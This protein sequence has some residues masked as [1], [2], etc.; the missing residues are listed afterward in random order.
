[1]AKQDNEI[2]GL[3]NLRKGSLFYIIA[4]ILEIIGLVLIVPSALTLTLSGI[5]SEIFTIIDEEII[6]VIVSE[7]LIILWFLSTRKGFKTLSNLGKD[8]RGGVTATTLILIGILIEIVGLLV[9]LGSI[10]A[11]LA[12]INTS[13][14][15]GGILG[16]V[17]ASIGAIVI[18]IIGAIIFF[19][20]SIMVGLAYRA[21]GDIYNNNNLRTGGLLIV[22]GNIL[23]IIPYLDI[24][25]AILVFIGYILVY[26]G[27]GSVITM[28]SKTSPQPYM[29]QSTLST[30]IPPQPSAPLSQIGTGKL[31][32]NGIAE[33]TIYSQVA[34]QI[35]SAA[36]LG[37]NN[38]TSDIFPAQLN[39]GYNNVKINFKV[40]LSLVAGNLYIIQLLL[41]NGQTL[42]TVVTYQ[43]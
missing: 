19:V 15:N 33:V 35:L 1:M 11:S 14:I 22:I 18:L 5:V 27:L 3:E 6:I 31:S 34:V 36:I 16:L 10:T 42:N 9:F 37:T 30:Q 21:T 38:I 43:P 4:A 40:S 13:N 20:G 12:T 7:I 8:V 2:S 26:S 23:S 41:S 32:S 29:Q 39:I 25:G 24:M 28:L 17:S